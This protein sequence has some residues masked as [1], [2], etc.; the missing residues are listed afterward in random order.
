MYSKLQN[1]F[2]LI[3]GAGRRLGRRGRWRTGV[4]G[5]CS[6]R[7]CRG[8]AEGGASA[9]TCT[10][11]E[12]CNKPD[13]GGRHLS[14]S[15]GLV[16]RARPGCGGGVERLPA[17]PEQWRLVGDDSMTNHR[18][19]AVPVAQAAAA[20]FVKSFV[21]RQKTEGGVRRGVRGDARRI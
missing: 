16:Y 6:T 19:M 10:L 17:H 2:M 3:C 18:A 8:V 4:F 11:A 20:V 13:R 15:C 21:E 1:S 7:R 14:S 12:Q 9:A 5:K